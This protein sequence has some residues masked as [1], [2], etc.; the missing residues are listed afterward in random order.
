MRRDCSPFTRV[1]VHFDTECAVKHVYRS[2]EN[3]WPFSSWFKAAGAPS[4]RHSESPTQ[5]ND[6]A[7]RPR[8]WLPPGT[9]RTSTPSE[10]NGNGAVLEGSSAGQAHAAKPGMHA[11]AWVSHSAL[12]GVKRA[13]LCRGA[14]RLAVAR[15][16]GV[17]RT[18]G[19]VGRKMHRQAARGTREKRDTPRYAH[20]SAGAQV[21]YTGVIECTYMR[22]GSVAPDKSACRVDIKTGVS[23]G[24]VTIQVP[25]NTAVVV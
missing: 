17:R 10:P 6:D 12:C 13:A 21:V 4:V 20:T 23:V 1:C 15:L 11:P 19:G 14:L 5:A 8:R 25:K 22:W 9:T 7:V 18:R 3:L 16:P 24:P 2:I